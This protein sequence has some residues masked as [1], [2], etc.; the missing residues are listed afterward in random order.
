MSKWWLEQP[1][2]MIQTNLREIDADLDVDK[3]VK[4]IKNFN[5]NVVLF[6]T[7]GAVSNYP[8]SIENHYK[9][10]FLQNDLVNEVIDI[11]K[12]ND[13]RFIARFDFSK[14][15]KTIGDKHEEWLYKNERDDY[16]C[17]N[18]QYHTCINSDYQQEIA[19]EVVSE[20]INNYPVDGVFFNSIGYLTVDYSMKY[21][22]I[23]QCDNCKK[24]FFEF[25][26]LDLPKKEDIED[27]IYREYLQFKKHTINDWFYS[28]NKI[29][30]TKNDNVAICAAHYK[31][32][33]IW[34][35]ESHSSLEMLN[36]EWSYTAGYNV[37]TVKSTWDDFAVTNSAVH[38]IDFPFRHSGVTESLTALR[39]AQN[40]ANASWLDFYVIGTL[41]NQYD[42]VSMPIV[43]D[44]YLYYK[45]N[46]EYYTDINSDADVCII[47][48]AS[49]FSSKAEFRGI[50]NMLTHSHILFDVIS[51]DI[52]EESLDKKLKN[53]KVILLPDIQCIGEKGIKTI[54]DFVA[55]GGHIVCSGMTGY[56]DLFGKPQVT[57]RLKASGIKSLIKANKSEKGTYFNIGAND[58]STLKGIDD[59]DVICFIGQFAEYEIEDQCTSFLKY[60]GLVMFGPPEKCYFTGDTDT[61]GVICNNYGKGKSVFYPWSIG[62]NYYH[63]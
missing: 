61:P 58:R 30:K 1:L 39:I 8:T 16:V 49:P 41:E 32:C 23:C 15:N 56:R 51:S 7:G 59:L 57:N 43:K 38:F 3:Y 40:I 31:Y 18:D 37:K 6:N 27:P 29:I 12:K 55:S 33:D 19:A 47:N 52:L 25:S 17:Y 13:I 21:H 42:R 54:N 34:R 60:T 9:N 36:E 53:Y 22:G 5:A 11:L 50:Y 26:G 45:N 28:I 24:R 48:E 20:V 44:L 14:I 10:P 63:I 4:N 2:R 62:E 46:L 35:K